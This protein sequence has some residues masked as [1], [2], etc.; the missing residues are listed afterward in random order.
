M[1]ASTL[2]STLMGLSAAMDRRKGRGGPAEGSGAAVRGAEAEEKSDP[3]EAMPALYG[4]R[5]RGSGGVRARGTPSERALA[6][7]FEFRGP[8]EGRAGGRGDAGK[9]QEWVWEVV[10]RW[11]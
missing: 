6:A 5:G 1:M 2:S 3:R 10:R 7:K 8:K 4:S 11:L 9:R